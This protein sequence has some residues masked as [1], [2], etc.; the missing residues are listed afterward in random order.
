MNDAD[1]TGLSIAL[2]DGQKI[3]WAQGFG[4]SD[5]H[6]NVKATADSIYNVGSISKVFTATATLQ[7]AEQ[8]K[9][10][11]DQPL[12]KYL[13]EFSMRSR[14]GDIDKITPRNL[15]THHSGLPVNWM[16]GMIVRS[17]ESF[18][19][20]VSAVKDEYTAYPSDYIFSYSNL[21]YLLLGA[22]IERL[23]DTV[24][25]NYMD[26]NLLKPLG[27]TRS[28]FANSISSK[29][30]DK[31]KEIEA[32]PMRDLPASGLNSSANDIAR[33]M[34]MVLSDGSFK[35]Q[36][37]INSKLL[38]E[39]IKIQNSNVALDFDSKVGLGWMLNGL[40]VVGGGTVI[41]H[42]GLTI[43][44][45]SL[46]A[47]L[48][49][50]KLG[51]VVLSNSTTAQSIVSKIATETLKIA[52]ETK[53]GIT[54]PMQDKKEVVS[55]PLTPEI[56]QSFEGYFDT[57][58]GLI[59][60]NGKIDTLKTEFMG[61]EFELISNQENELRLRLKL[62]GI[63]PIRIDALERLRLSLHK[64]DG[65]EVLTLKNNGQSILVGEKLSPAYIPNHFLDFI[66]S[67][68]VLNMPDGP[69]FD[70]VQVV[71]KD[72]YLIGEFAFPKK[73]SGFPFYPGYIYRTALKPISENAVVLS[74]LGPGKGETVHLTK[75]DGEEF[76]AISGFKFRKKSVALSPFRI[77]SNI[78]H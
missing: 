22:T 29:S 62:F 77:T 4:Y 23:S 69:F 43:N 35:G 1:V 49:D 78:Q 76:L 25:A 6:D 66:G 20:V 19:K 71:L 15:M 14:Y 58:I 44:F 56:I 17:P 37:I 41:S 52:L 27:M 8:G 11:I 61:Q 57:L 38:N 9:L 10:D 64:I 53:T 48:P 33:F 5:L 70:T 47:L 13:P 34:L 28:E 31:G 42:G 60:V 16:Q 7:L 26:A 36:Q 30:Y 50:K 63:I 72:G 59:K 21:G 74:G 75:I 2:V 65:R 46:M 54:Q 18:T 51:V 68:E 24:Y 45:H 73:E 3:I 55:V 67:Y 40:D 32:I 12:R 39:M